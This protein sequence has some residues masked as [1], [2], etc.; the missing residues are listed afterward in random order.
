MLGILVELALSWLILWLFARKHLPVLG[1]VP[2]KNRLINL[3]IGFVL[4][5]SCCFLYFA[6]KS[7]FEKSGWTINK[8]FTAMAALK[9]SWWVF[10]S[11]LF[12]ELI[13][14]G[15]LLY[16]AI[17]FIGVVKACLLSAI[18]FGIYHWFSFNAFGN[19][20]QMLF[21]FLMTGTWGYMF[22]MAFAKT[23]SL[24]LP[25]ALHFGWN[26]VNIVVFSYGPL[27]E[28]LIYKY[29]GPPLPGIQ[30]IIVFAFQLFPLPVLVFWYLR[31][32]KIRSF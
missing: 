23:K 32:K 29:R 15:A 4:A 11:V 5:A 18:C 2:T 12:E 17:K 27:G 13:F 14:R 9:S 8:S 16:L 31:S 24:Y 3:L 19:P 1:I 26:L 25:I 20:V 10:I 6:V 30:S 7:F 21:I 28:Q 22:A